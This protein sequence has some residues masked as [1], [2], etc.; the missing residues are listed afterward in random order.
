ME[1]LNKSYLIL[2]NEYEN[3]KK[4]KETLKEQMANFQ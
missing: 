4:A 3:E 1:I 2:E